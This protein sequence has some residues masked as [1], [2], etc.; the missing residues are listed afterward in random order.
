MSDIGYGYNKATNIYIQCLHT[1]KER[2][3]IIKYS[4]YIIIL[5]LN[6]YH[7]SIV[8]ILYHVFDFGIY[9]LLISHS[10]FPNMGVIS[11]SIPFRR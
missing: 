11:V 4:Y 10:H 1:N 8:I 7:G 2:L 9:A 5:I 6:I 3:Y